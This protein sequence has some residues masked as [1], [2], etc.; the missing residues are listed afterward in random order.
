MT[1]NDAGFGQKRPQFVGNRVDV[2]NAIMQIEHL[3]L[4]VDLALDGVAD[5]SLVVLRDNRLDW[6]TVLRRSFDRAH[7]ARAGQ[8]QMK[9]ARDRGGAQRENI[10]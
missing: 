1:N 5:N 8:S 3:A 9:C 10:D 2:E 6:Q 7:V 4:A